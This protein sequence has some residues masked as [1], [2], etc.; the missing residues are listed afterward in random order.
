MNKKSPHRYRIWDLAKKPGSDTAREVDELAAMM[1]LY[2]YR[3]LIDVEL[4]GTFTK[5]NGTSA[6]L[7]TKTISPDAV[8]LIYDGQ[9]GDG[10]K[11]PDGMPEGSVV[12]L[13]VDRIGAFRGVVASKESAGFQVAVDDKCRP[14][15]RDRLARMAAEHAVSLDSP[16]TRSCIA[17]IEPAIRTC[18]FIDHTGTLRQG[19]IVNVSKTD[20]LIRARIVPPQGSRVIFRGSCR[21]AAEVT[22]A[23]EMG[24]AVRFCTLVRPEELSAVSSE[25]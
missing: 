16:L 19:T 22:Q 5:R 4:R 6:R 23:F 11:R 14:V 24:F 10:G 25:A 8:D 21:Y 3:P 7:K 17:K 18:S 1:A 12:H 13:D 20:A 15:L 2:D 9:N